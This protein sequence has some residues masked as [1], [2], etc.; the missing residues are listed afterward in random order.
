MDIMAK[1]LTVQGYFYIATGLW[2]ILQIK[3]FEMVSGPKKDKWL[4]RTLGAMI[5]CS[6]IIFI[7][8]AETKAALHLAILNAIA[9]ICVDVYYVVK[10]IIWKT[11]LIDAGI[12]GIFLMI[13]FCVK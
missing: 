3:S 11:Y 8:H 13:Y 6:G 9:L 7:N 4:V 10:K 2:P 1:T 12:E 5:T